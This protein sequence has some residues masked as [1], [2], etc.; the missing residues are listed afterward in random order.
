MNLPASEHLSTASSAFA[1]KGMLHAEGP[2]YVVSPMG[3]AAKFTA[4]FTTIAGDQIH[5]VRFVW[6]D[7][8][9]LYEL[10]FSNTGED[11][12]SGIADAVMQTLRIKPGAA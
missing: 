9:T 2:V 4:N 1:V 12:V 6:V 10:R 3:K 7:V 5:E 11:K 8:Q